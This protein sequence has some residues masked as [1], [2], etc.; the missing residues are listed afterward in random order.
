MQG[1]RRFAISHKRRLLYG[2]CGILAFGYAVG[3]YLLYY[4][5]DWIRN[6]HKRKLL[7]YEP[8][9]VRRTPLYV[10]GKSGTP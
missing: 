6:Y 2:A 4:E 10:A 8:P 3:G 1:A 5:R 7:R 9:P